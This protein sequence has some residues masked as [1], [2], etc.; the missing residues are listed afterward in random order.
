MANIRALVPPAGLRCPKCTGNA[1]EGSRVP[2]S[3]G[4]DC[5][6]HGVEEGAKMG[7]ARVGALPKRIAV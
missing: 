1:G 2:H 6:G 3:S 5:W 7:F 4:A